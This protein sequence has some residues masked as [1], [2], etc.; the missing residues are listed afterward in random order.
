MEMR[1]WHAGV[2]VSRGGCQNFRC[3]GDVLGGWL[4][5]TTRAESDG[6]LWAIKIVRRTGAYKKVFGSSTLVW[7]NG[8]GFGSFCGL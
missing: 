8:F 1:G 3:G 2:V 5:D 4:S 6:A 7:M